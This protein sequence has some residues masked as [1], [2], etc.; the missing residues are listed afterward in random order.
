LPTIPAFPTGA[1]PIWEIAMTNS[2]KGMTAGFIATVVLSAL[3]MLKSSMALAPHLNIINLLTQLGSI[4]TVAAWMDHFI[5]GTVVWGLLFGAFDAVYEK[6]AYWLKGIMFGVFAWL[7]MM[8]VFMPL[9]KAGFFGSK[10]GL[11]APAVTLVYHLV[12]GAVLGVIYGLLTVWMPIK[13]P[14]GAP[15]RP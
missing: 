4:G 3:L 13:S 15:P 7:L 5:V 12:Y 9:V 10:I 14:A 11:E 2:M 1:C 8:I 6:G